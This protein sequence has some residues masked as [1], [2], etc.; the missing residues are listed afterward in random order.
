M[1]FYGDEGDEAT[2]KQA[3]IL[4]R[5]R[6]RRRCDTTT[7]SSWLNAVE[8]FFSDI[9]NKRIRRGTFRSVRELEKAIRTCVAEHNSD[10]K[11]FVWRKSARTILRKIK[12][13]HAI[14]GSGH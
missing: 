10:A 3:A 9:T 14:Y 7:S 12:K 8:R 2:K 11:P 1:V 5:D 6:K 4:R 13:C